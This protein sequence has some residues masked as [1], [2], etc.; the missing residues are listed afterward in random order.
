MQCVCAALDHNQRICL[1]Q[2]NQDPSLISRSRLFL[3]DALCCVFK[4]P[5]LSLNKCRAKQSR[6]AS[7]NLQRR[8]KDYLGT[9]TCLP[10][11]GP[12]FAIKLLLRQSDRLIRK[13]LVATNGSCF[14]Y[15]PATAK[16]LFTRHVS[17]PGSS[18]G[19]LDRDF[20]RELC[21]LHLAYLVLLIWLF[22]DQNR[23]IQK[24]TP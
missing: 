20:I 15:S 23:A 8:C 18:S 11:L 19:E 9:G 14:A 17:E 21:N 12:L 1:G 16:C 6:V 24:I 2:S 7:H 3:A 22:L 10:C 5:C 13:Q 4:V